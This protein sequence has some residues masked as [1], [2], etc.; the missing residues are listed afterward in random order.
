MQVKIAGIYDKLIIG[1]LVLLVVLVTL[2][3]TAT[4]YAVNEPVKVMFMRIITLLII[5]LWLVRI[6]ESGELSLR[7]TPLDVPLMILLFV[8]VLATSVSIDP[9]LSTWGQLYRYE[10]LVTVINYVFIYYVTVNFVRKEGDRNL[11]IGGILLISGL[12]AIYAVLQRFGIDIITWDPEVMDVTRSFATFGNPVF[13]GAYLT[14]VLPIAVVYAL[15]FPISRHSGIQ[16]TRYPEADVSYTTPNL[17]AQ[18]A[19]GSRLE[20]ESEEPGTR[21]STPASVANRGQAKYEAPAVIQRVLRIGSI[22]L[23]PLLIAALVFSYTRAAWLGFLGAFVFIVLFSFGEIWRQK[24]IALMII[25]S[26]IV[27]LVLF[28]FVIAKGSAGEERDLISRIKSIVRTS[29]GSV[30]SRLVLWDTTLRMIKTR[31]LLGFGPDTYALAFQRYQPA[32]WYKIIK[33]EAQPDKAHNEMLQIAVTAGLLGLIVYTWLLLTFIFKGLSTI[34]KTSY[35]YRAILVGLIGG[36]IGYLI[37]IQLSFSIIS[38]APLFWL[39]MGLTMSA[40]K[41]EESKSIDVRFFEAGTP[42][43]FK[44]ISYPIIVVLT[45]LLS[46]S[47]IRP[48]L[49]DQHMRKAWANLAFNFWDDAVEE[50]EYAVKLNP[51]EARYFIRLGEAYLAKY[52]ADHEPSSREK[53][54]S[55][56]ETARKMSPRNENIY[57]NL[58]G[59]YIEMGKTGDA[60]YYDEAIA[61]YKKVLEL[62]PNDVSAHFDLGIAYAN[63]NKQDLAIKEWEKSLS[64]DPKFVQ[65][66]LVLGRAYELKEDWETAK[67]MYQKALEIDSGNV[68]AQKALENLGNK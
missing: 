64:L 14:L 48:F 34:I 66:Y 25:V 54:F 22:L 12:V 60:R 9:H 35:P 67:R 58:G 49:A 20:V 28:G 63:R 51:G 33:E 3:Q 30:A 44:A 59:L 38:V 62:S 65:S 68:Y 19:Q 18:K 11:L 1:A 36:I 17:E 39:L 41:T 6:I 15:F 4:T 23:V 31:P 55:A 5:A 27:F 57:F 2:A 10:G 7:R 45:V 24:R 13:L 21:L 56:L 37:Q 42:K 52:R 8:M 40:M 26:L 53:A 16:I 32:D 47:A 46:F 43:F 29:E 61:N 50:L